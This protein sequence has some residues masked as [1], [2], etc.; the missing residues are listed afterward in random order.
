M[1]ADRGAGA[2]DAARRFSSPGRE[3][4]VQHA[5]SLYWRARADVAAKEVQA[6]QHVEIKMV[7]LQQ[8]LDPEDQMA[9][10]GHLGAL[11]GQEVEAKMEEQVA[12]VEMETMEQLL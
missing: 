12:M 9:L 2:R 6:G 7:K 4:L 3:R 11:A 8:A 1:H 5:A 10:Q